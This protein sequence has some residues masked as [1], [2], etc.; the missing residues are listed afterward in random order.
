MD[1]ILCGGNKGILQVSMM[2]NEVQRVLKTGSVNFVVSYG[3]PDSRA[4]F[5]QQPFLGQ[6]IKVYQI[7]DQTKT[8]ASEEEKAQ[9][10]HYIYACTKLENADQYSAQYYEDQIATIKASLAQLEQE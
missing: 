2:L 10:S 8:F 4:L 3:D 6:N 1:C 5:F 9:K 7:F